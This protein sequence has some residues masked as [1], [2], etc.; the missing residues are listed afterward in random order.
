[1]NR[2]QIRFRISY[3][4]SHNLLHRHCHLPWRQALRLRLPR[5]LLPDPTLRSILP[6]TFSFSLISHFQFLFLFLVIFYLLFSFDLV[7]IS[8]SILFYF[9][10]EIFNRIVY[11]TTVLHFL[12]YIVRYCLYKQLI[13]SS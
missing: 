7:L 10:G 1:M 12:S 9:L 13:C 6:Y 11:K 3:S 4:G 5:L 2:I 8:I